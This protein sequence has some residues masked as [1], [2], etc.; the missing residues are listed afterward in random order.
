MNKFETFFL[1]VLGQLA[2]GDPQ[3]INRV[4]LAWSACMLPPRGDP[5][6]PPGPVTLEVPRHLFR[7]QVT[8]PAVCDFEFY[9]AFDTLVAIV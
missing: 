6:P 7:P 5:R 8:E 4:A 2:G 1:K 9:P 3:F